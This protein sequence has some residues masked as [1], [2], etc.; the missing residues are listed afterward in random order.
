M[1]VR[2]TVTILQGWYKSDEE[3]EALDTITSMFTVLYAESL[4]EQKAAVSNF[5]KLYEY[6]RESPVRIAVYGDFCAMF[7]QVFFCYLFSLPEIALG[8]VPWDSRRMVDYVG[9]T[10]LLASLPEEDKHKMFCTFQQSHAWPTNVDIGPYLAENEDWLRL[11]E[12]DQ[13]RRIAA[14]GDK[15]EPK[16]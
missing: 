10:A 16:K 1:F 15:K 13:Q 8:L 12:E 6:M 14:G 11:I 2:Q 5:R 7:V 3:I 9:M 4:Q